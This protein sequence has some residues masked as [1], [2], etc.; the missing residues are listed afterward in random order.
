M[1]FNAARTGGPPLVRRRTGSSSLTT[2]IVHAV[3]SLENEDPSALGPLGEAVDPEALE[4]L[5]EGP[6]SAAHVTFSYADHQ[7]VVTDD[8]VEVY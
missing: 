8:A 6:D 3:A 4:R 2:A 5:L 7:V 1:N